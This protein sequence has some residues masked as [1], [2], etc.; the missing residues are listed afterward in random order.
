MYSFPL[1]RTHASSHSESPFT[2]DTPTP[3]SPPD[4]LYAL[5]SNFPPECNVVSTS[6]K[7]DF[8]YFGCSRTGIPRP[9]SSTVTEP[10]LLSSTTIFVAYLFTSHLV[11]TL[12]SSNFF[13]NF[14]IPS[15]TWNFTCFHME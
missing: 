9:S 8:L 15:L 6:S 5:L 1:R 11:Y 10:S 4:T 3:C 7:P 14:F 13:R 12:K 2:Q